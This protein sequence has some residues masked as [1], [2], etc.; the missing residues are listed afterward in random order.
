M[1]DRTATRLLLS[2]ILLLGLTAGSDARDRPNLL[3][4]MM[5]DLG[6]GQCEFHNGTLRVEAFDSY[7][8]EL[9]ARRQDYSPE[10]AL[11]FSREAI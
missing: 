3:F 4:I 9:V 10:Q 8:K 2:T 6:Y 7:F 11:E 5:D 1:K